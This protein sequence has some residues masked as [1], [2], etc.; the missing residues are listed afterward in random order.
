MIDVDAANLWGTYTDQDSGNVP[1]SAYE[2][3]HL[4]ARQATVILFRQAP[5]LDSSWLESFAQAHWPHPPS[6]A[7]EIMRMPS[8]E[9]SGSCARFCLLLL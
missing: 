2:T 9:V 1:R 4:Q 3:F 8:A 6:T 7:T 5:Y